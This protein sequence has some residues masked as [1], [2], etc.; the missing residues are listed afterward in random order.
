MFV[1]VADRLLTRPTTEALEGMNSLQFISSIVASLAWPTAVVV[2]VITLRRPLRGLLTRLDSFKGPGLEASFG[3]RIE[4]VNQE[5]DALEIQASAFELQ[6]SLDIARTA[7]SETRLD[8]NIRVFLGS[9]LR[10]QHEVRVDGLQTLAEASPRAAILEAWLWAEAEAIKTAHRVG[11]TPTEGG[12]GLNGAVQ[13]IRSL[14]NMGVV[15]ASIGRPFRELRRLRDRAVHSTEFEASK[16]AV[17]DYIDSIGKIVKVL[18]SVPDQ[19]ELEYRTYPSEEEALPALGILEGLSSEA[20][21]VLRKF[22]D[23]YVYNLHGRAAEG[24]FAP[25]GGSKAYDELVNA[26]LLKVVPPPYGEPTPP[27]DFMVTTSL[28]QE[29]GRLLVGYGPMPDYVR[30]LL[31]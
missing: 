22:I 13:A 15:P 30:K 16:D 7:N 11:A 2:A 24:L 1:G 17:L 19:R 18:T 14:T 23:D 10:S 28:G 5:T 21:G 25:S 4:A 6:A 20:I 12:H 29:V 9:E 3:A 8:K 31:A 26:G 27:A